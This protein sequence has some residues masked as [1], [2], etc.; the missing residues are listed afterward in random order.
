MNKEQLAR[1]LA[2]RMGN[3]ASDTKV[4]VEAFCDTLEDALLK[5]ERVV[6]TGFGTFSVVRYKPSETTS[7]KGGRMLI[8]KGVAVHFH[9]G[10]KLKK[11]IN[12]KE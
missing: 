5:Q 7:V 8:D 6:L 4:F 12:H 10:P 1:K 2:L 3:K 9:A 11:I